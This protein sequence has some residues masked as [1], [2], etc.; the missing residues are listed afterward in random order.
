MDRDNHGDHGRGGKG[1]AQPAA[2]PVR[3]EAQGGGQG[4]CGQASITTGEGDLD[5]CYS[6]E[7]LFG[8]DETAEQGDK[9]G[10]Q[11]QQLGGPD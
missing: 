1:V 8:E 6:M 4:G 11:S 10:Q 2:E 3:H 5:A 7:A 9:G